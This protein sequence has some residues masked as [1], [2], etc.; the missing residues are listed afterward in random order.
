MVACVAS[1][2]EG[3]VGELVTK[4]IVPVS[5]AKSVS[6]VSGMVTSRVHNLVAGR[7]TPWGNRVRLDW[8]IYISTEYN[9][10]PK[11][12]YTSSERGVCCEE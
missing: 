11:R 8:D 4:C 1:S 9:V 2:T 10:P 6:T 7:A 5:N 3:I 12:V